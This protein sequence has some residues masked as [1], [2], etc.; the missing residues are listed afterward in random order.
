MQTLLLVSWG[1]W[2][3]RKIKNKDIR[4]SLV[5]EV[6]KGDIRTVFIK[7]L[8]D[9]FS[10]R[11]PVFCINLCHF[12][13]QE[14]YQTQGLHF[15]LC[16]HEFSTLNFVRDNIFNVSPSSRA[17]DFIIV[18]FPLRRKLLQIEN[19]KIVFIS[20][21]QIPQ[22]SALTRKYRLWDR[23]RGG[24]TVTTG[25]FSTPGCNNKDQRKLCN[26]G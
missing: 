10:N 3:L 21:S 15:R 19:E 7:I 26:Y 13:S 11:L 20:F 23:W 5:N 1:L 8:P 22:C 18:D 9:S 12:E 17:L 4:H 14:I 6:L 25:L 24:H 2:R 16:D